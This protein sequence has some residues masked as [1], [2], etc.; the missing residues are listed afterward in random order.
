M[1][2]AKKKFDW[3]VG[4]QTN[5]KWSNRNS[6]WNLQDCWL[7]WFDASNAHTADT[8]STCG[9][10]QWSSFS[11]GNRLYHDF[12]QPKMSREVLSR[13]LNRTNFH[14]ILKKVSYQICAKMPKDYLSL[15]KISF[16]QWKYMDERPYFNKLTY[17]LLPL[18]FK[19]R[20]D[21]GPE[22]QLI[23]NQIHS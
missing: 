13:V 12:L 20:V 2:G 15:V 5:F 14:T 7:L 23:T 9:L 4:R 18:T 1:Q 16:V 10:I 22:C 11:C 3:N 19:C 8:S 6:D 17:T 21:I